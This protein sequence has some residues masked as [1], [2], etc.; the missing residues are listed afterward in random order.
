MGSVQRMAGGRE[1]DAAAM[2]LVQAG[3]SALAVRWGM[4]V[5]LGATQVGTAQTWVLE[6]T[7]D[8]EGRG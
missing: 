6:H 3:A 2:A 7:R 5:C 1:A 8:S 4:G